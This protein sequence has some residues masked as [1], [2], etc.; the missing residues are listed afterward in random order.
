ME[1]LD[2]QY[3]NIKKTTIINKLEESEE[4]RK[5]ILNDKVNRAKLV[6]EKEYIYFFIRCNS[7]S[8]SPHS[9]KQYSTLIL[10]KMICIDANDFAKLQQEVKKLKSKSKRIKKTIISKEIKWEEENEFDNQKLKYNTL[11]IEI[12]KL[13]T[14]NPLDCHISKLETVLKIIIKTIQ[15]DS[16]IFLSIRYCNIIE[17]LLKFISQTYLEKSQNLSYSVIK[18]LNKIL[19]NDVKTCEYI[20]SNDIFITFLNLAMWGISTSIDDL[21]VLSYIILILKTLYRIDINNDNKKIL[22]EKLLLGIEYLCSCGFIRYLSS[23]FEVWRECLPI[24]MDYACLLQNCI[25]LLEI[26]TQLSYIY[27]I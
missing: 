26:W 25:G 23:R 10:P 21:D 7:E 11:A 5:K 8:T 2:K 20:I 13:Y 24:T 1:F 6:G 4:R 14:Q 3:N 17:K 19:T 12:D 18:V 16:T 15:M 9:R 22:K 27:I